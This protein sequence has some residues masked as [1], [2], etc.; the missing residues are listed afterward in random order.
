MKKTNMT[1]KTIASAL[2]AIVMAGTFGTIAY[3]DKEITSPE[4]EYV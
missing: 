1:Q 2:A 3:A 4:V